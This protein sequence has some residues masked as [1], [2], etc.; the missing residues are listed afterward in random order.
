MASIEELRSRYKL[1]GKLS[2]PSKPRVR[3]NRKPGSALTPPAQ[4][5][6]L[7]KLVPAGAWGMLANDSLGDCVCAGA[8]HGQQLID[9]AGKGVD[10]NF[11]NNDAIVMYEKIAG[12]V[13][14]NPRTDQGAELIDG[15]KYWANPGLGAGQFKCDAYAQFD[16]RDQSMMKQLIADFGVVYLALEVPASAMS[17]FDKGQPW[18][19]VSRSPIEGGHCIPGVDYDENYLYAV[20][21]NAIQPIAWSF[22]TKYFDEGWAVTSADLVKAAGGTIATG[23]DTATA[24]ADWHSLT[25]DTSNPFPTVTPV[26][27]VPPI[28][29]PDPPSPNPPAVDA[30]TF[31][32]QIAGDLGEAATLMSEGAQ[33]ALNLQSEI[34]GWIAANGGSSTPPPHHHGH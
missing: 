27:P 34:E 10:T 11:T 18:T 2:D 30:V 20:T 31:L 4:S 14:G 17:Q 9:K 24:N 21:W 5:N 23:I 15:L 19:V 25:G 3:L 8:L 33:D 1:G 7:S 6:G 32:T 16:V 22:V 26:P 29:P 28:N 12:Y 13:P